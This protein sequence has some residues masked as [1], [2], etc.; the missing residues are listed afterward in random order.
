MLL[1]DYAPQRGAAFDLLPEWAGS[2]GGLRLFVQRRHRLALYPEVRPTPLAARKLARCLLPAGEMASSCALLMPSQNGLRVEA[3]ALRRDAFQPLT[4]AF[5][6]DCAVQVEPSVGE[7]AK[8][9][10]RLAERFSVVVEEALSTATIAETFA[11]AGRRRDD[12]VRYLER[13][14]KELKERERAIAAVD[15]ALAAERELR[16]AV[17]A[18]LDAAKQD[19]RTLLARL[20]ALASGQAGEL[21]ILGEVRRQAEALLELT[22]EQQALQQRLDELRASIRALAKR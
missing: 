18:A 21:K 9:S 20:N 19:Q 10:Q 15:T 16:A 3:I 13:L 5:E 14:V 8:V 22:A 11:R 12:L 17:Q 1:R 2:R 4:R 7:A 6:W